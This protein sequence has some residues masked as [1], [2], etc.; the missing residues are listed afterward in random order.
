MPV[1]QV[2]E[3][4]VLTPYHLAQALR[5][6]RKGQAM[7]QRDAAARGALLQKTVSALETA[8]ERA[9]IESL[10]KLLS[11]LGVELVL[12]DRPPGARRI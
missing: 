7:T 3:Y 11:A 12:R 6:F 5:G 1:K 4:P 9:S 8:P 10:F 2:S